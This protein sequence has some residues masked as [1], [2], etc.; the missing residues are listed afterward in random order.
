MYSLVICA[1]WAGTPVALGPCGGRGT[2]FYVAFICYFL[3]WRGPPI[4]VFVTIYN[5]AYYFYFIFILVFIFTYSFL[6]GH[7]FFHTR[8]TG[9]I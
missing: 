7:G 4:W 6:L 9:S 5:G 3:F 8:A 1:A 2:V